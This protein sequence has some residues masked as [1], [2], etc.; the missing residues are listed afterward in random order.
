VTVATIIVVIFVAYTVLGVAFAIAFVTRG[1]E[2]MD[3]D[4]R[5]GPVSFRL[6]IFP[7]S[8]GLWPYLMIRWLRAR[9]STRDS[10]AYRREQSEEPMT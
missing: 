9:R 8:A 5:G 10:D 1:A 3:P 7:A 2:R 4:A 6:L